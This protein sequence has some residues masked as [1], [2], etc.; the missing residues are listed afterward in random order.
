MKKIKITTEQL[1]LLSKIITESNKDDIT[2]KIASELTSYYEPTV[3]TNK[4]GGEY[5]DKPMI[6][7]KVSNE[8]ISPKALLDYI[9]HKYQ[10]LNDAY[11]EQVIRDWFDG[12]L[13]NGNNLSANVKM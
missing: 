6:L 12:K 4:K 7:N 13:K 9:K 3:A 10:G 2:K 1:A 5:F 8:I 11:I